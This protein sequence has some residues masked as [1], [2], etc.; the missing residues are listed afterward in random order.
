MEVTDATGLPNEITN[1]LRIENEQMQYSI[2]KST[3]TSLILINERGSNGS[4]VSSHS[5]N[6]LIDTLFTSVD[7]AILVEGYQYDENIVTLQ[8]ALETNKQVTTDVLAHK[9]KVRYF[10]PDITVMYSPG[11]NKAAV[12][13]SI[14]LSLVSYFRSLYFGNEIQMSD[15]LQTVH[16]VG[17]VDNV[18]W[19]KDGLDE[20]GLNYDANG[21]ARSRIVETNQ[22]GVPVGSPVLDRVEIGN[23]ITPTEYRIYLPY[24]PDT[25]NQNTLSA[26]TGLT[27]T[28]NYPSAVVT[29]LGTNSGTTNV[30][31]VTDSTGMYVGMTIQAAG[32]STT[33]YIT[34]ITA[35]ALTLN[36]TVAWSGVSGD[37][38]AIPPNSSTYISTGKTYSYVI[39]ALND[40]GQ[41]IASS[42]VTKAT[43]SV[44]G[45]AAIN[46]DW[47]A[48]DGATHY[49]VY[50]NTTGTSFT[51]GPKLLIGIVHV[52]EG[53]S[54]NDLGEVE[55]PQLAGIPPTVN[56]ATISDF[57]PEQLSFFDIQYSRNEPIRIQYDDFSTDIYEESKSYSAG[58][59]V[60]YGSTYYRSLLDENENHDPIDPGSN[61]WWVVDTVNKIGFQSKIN[62][63][64]KN[65]IVDVTDKSGTYNFLSGPSYNNYLT[66][67][68]KNPSSTEV[69]Q[70][71]N[72][73]VNGGSGVFQGDFKIGDDE[74]GSL[75]VGQ[76]D[77]NGNL[78][79]SSVITI[80]AK[81]QNTW[82]NPT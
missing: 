48:V 82:G 61:V 29:T 59:I 66:I 57:T 71:T 44:F 4:Y 63:Y 38:H 54:F 45:Y 70:I 21:D 35:N 40:V 13:E 17:G 22:Y 8:S 46:L 34:A 65:N 69:L 20:S 80:R 73:T 51:T 64:G 53:T 68:Y 30:L 5:A 58:D 7:Q 12:N 79:L 32:I 52:D 14:R 81:S 26:P 18:R 10:K 50:R 25:L 75:P 76:M 37:V 49:R 78:D 24:V 39:T 31:N 62:S 19:S 60:L 41:T 72:S 56:T 74:L 9:A 33:R 67:K 43:G 47:N 15:I 3:S 42:V 16:N 77:T 28:L 36:G 6:S 2:P 11:I 55:N 1:Y 27:A 23:G